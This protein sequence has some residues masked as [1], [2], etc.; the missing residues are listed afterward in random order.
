MVGL[1]APFQHHGVFRQLRDQV[2]VLD[3]D[4]SPEV[5]CATVTLDQVVDAKQVVE[6]DAADSLLL[7]GPGAPATANVP[8]LVAAYVELLAREMRKQLGEQH[9]YELDAA[10]VCWVQADGWHL[11]GVPLPGEL[12]A[13]RALGQVLVSCPLQP[14]VHV[15]EGVLAGYQLHK[16]LA[17]IGVEPEYVLTGHRASLRPYLAVVL[18]GEGMLR[19]QF[20]VVDLPPGEQVDQT[21]ERLE[22]GDLAPADIEHHPARREI[23]RVL[24]LTRRERPLALA[25]HLHQRHD[26]VECP[27]RVTGNEVYSVVSNP[28]PVALRGD[29]PLWRERHNRAVPGTV[30]PGIPRPQGP[31]DT[32]VLPERLLQPVGYR[33][34]RS[35][36]SLT[37]DLRAA[38][39]PVSARTGDDRARLGEQDQ[40]FDRCHDFDWSPLSERPLS[41]RI[42]RGWATCYLRPGWHAPPMGHSF[43]P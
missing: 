37:D 31:P 28:Q 34:Q 2:R 33:E 10:P 14:V 8:G 1:V 6:V 4:V 20:E 23:R 42:E 26:A 3:Y 25:Q 12:E 30:D 19:V 41:H 38:G 7:D 29:A 32:L 9:S 36:L 16:P 18:V 39:E 35:R 22:G 40:V 17:T 24:D 13:L 27:G 43:P 15:P 5:H 11:P 21:E